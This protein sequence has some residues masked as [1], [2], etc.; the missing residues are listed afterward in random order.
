M[1]L[2]RRGKRDILTAEGFGQF[3]ILTLGIYDD[4]IRI[5][6]GKIE[7]DNLLLCHNGLTRTRNAGNKGVAVK[8]LQ[9]ID[10]NHILADGVIAEVQTFFVADL[11]CS[12]RHK[13][14]KTFGCESSAD[15]QLC[16]AIG[17]A[18]FESFKLLPTKNCEGAKVLSRT[19]LNT[20]GICVKLSLAICRMNDCDERGDHP[21]VALHKVVKEITALVA[22]PFHFVGY[23]CRVVVVLVL[24]TLPIRDIGFHRQELVFALPYRLFLRDRLGINGEHHISVDGGQL[25]Y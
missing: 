12:E 2:T 8:Q 19:L 3:P 13:Y 11:L 5:L 7:I 14:R 4:N 6:V 10:H 16:T 18:G 24:L 20:L 22:L 25:G 17:Q 15:R 23:G 9:A 21:H 1:V